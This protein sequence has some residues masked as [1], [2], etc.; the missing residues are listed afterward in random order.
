MVGKTIE[1][2]RRKGA[3]FV[4][5][6]DKLVEQSAKGFEVPEDYS[7]W[8]R[9]EMEFK[10]NNASSVFL[11]Y[12]MS[13]DDKEFIQKMRGEAFSLIRFVDLDHSRRYNCTVCKWWLDFLA[14]AAVYV[15]PNHKPKHNKFVRQLAYQRRQNSASLTTLVMCKPKVLKSILLEGAKKFSKTAEAIANDYR[16]V[17]YLSPEEFERVYKE[18]TKELNGLEFWQ[19][20]TG[21]TKA[22]KKEFEEFI[23]KALD[24]FCDSAL[25]LLGVGRGE[26]KQ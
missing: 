1:L 23:D 24:L 25:E 11:Q 21:L 22:D 7:S 8:I 9:F 17:Q 18:E 2:G 6:Y 26:A 15:L 5:F 14:H 16:A 10:H 12:A 3:S 4:R 19:Q 13:K 20:F